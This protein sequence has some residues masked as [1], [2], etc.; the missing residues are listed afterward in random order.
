[1]Q[2]SAG[3]AMNFWSVIVLN[4]VLLYRQIPI[5]VLNVAHRTKIAQTAGFLSQRT[6]ISA[7]NVVCFRST[8]NLHHQQM[9]RW[10]RGTKRVLHRHDDRIEKTRQ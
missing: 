5:I 8:V 3:I 1:M 6:Q 2:S 10:V 7:L 4:V 9:G